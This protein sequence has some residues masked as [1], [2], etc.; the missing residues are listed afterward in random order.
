MWDQVGREFFPAVSSHNEIPQMLDHPITNLPLIGEKKI[1][2]L[3]LPVGL[4]SDKYVPL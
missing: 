1:D 3:L 4:S 2:L